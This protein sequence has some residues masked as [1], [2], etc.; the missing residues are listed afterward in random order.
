[1][2]AKK[3]MGTI[4]EHGARGLA[5]FAAEAFVSRQQSAG[6]PIGAGFRY[7]QA[8]FE[9]RVK[10]LAAAVDTGHSRLFVSQ[11]RWC[12]AAMV[13]RGVGSDDIRDAIETLREVIA[14]Q[15]D[16]AD[17]QLAHQ[18]L[19]NAVEDFSGD[20]QLPDTLLDVSTLHGRLAAEFVLSILEGRRLDACRLILDALSDDFSVEDA[21]LKVVVPAVREFGRM[22]HMDEVTIAAE[23]FA[24][25]TAQMVIAQ[26]QAR[27]PIAPSNGRVL[28]AA[29][30]AG[31][32]HDMGPRI[33]ANLFEIAG[34]RV[35]CL[36]G[37]MPGSDIALAVIDF[38]ADLL[39]LSATL[40][41]HLRTV[42][43]TIE[44][45]RARSDERAVR[46]LAGGPAFDEAPQ[47]ANQYGA[48]DYAASAE[49]A[50]NLGRQWFSL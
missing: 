35:V 49:E 6:K 43:R 4:L 26:L 5:G 50:L 9:A 46:V 8:F 7:W 17:Y 33:I 1:M 47:L 39:L 32:R 41:T 3:S 48:D 29:S 16:E 25:D 31:N 28:L 18:Y 27:A 38:D 13:A 40:H 24:S 20:I 10:D 44:L 23:H 14:S 45:V 11:V 22:W 21:Y 30:V 19:A 2:Q 37:D 12:R 34:W 15:A 36:G 42:E